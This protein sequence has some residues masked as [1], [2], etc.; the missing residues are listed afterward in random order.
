MRSHLTLSPQ[1]ECRSF[2]PKLACNG[3]VVSVTSLRDAK[4]E[5]LHQLSLLH[6]KTGSLGR[7]ASTA[8]SMLA[9]LVGV[10]GYAP[11]LRPAT[12]ARRATPYRAMPLMVGP[13]DADMTSPRVRTVCV[14]LLGQLTKLE[15]EIGVLD[16]N[17]FSAFVDKLEVECDIEDKQ[18]IFAMID[19]DGG[20][21]V[22]RPPGAS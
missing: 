12:V 3:R 8:A 7:C 6:S 14:A 4:R 17:G 15:E 13:D 1:P 22:R 19:K 10:T 2:R 9:V 18:S 5:K 21:T 20:G 16:F 11:A